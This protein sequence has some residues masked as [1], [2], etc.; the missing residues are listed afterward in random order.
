MNH[1]PGRDLT[2]YDLAYGSYMYG[3]RP[4]LGAW[5]IKGHHNSLRLHVFRYV[6]SCALSLLRC[7]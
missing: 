7:F 6:V 3:S 4:A 1:I 2:L 5:G